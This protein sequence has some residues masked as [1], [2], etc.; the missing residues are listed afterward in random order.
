MEAPASRI[1]VYWWTNMS[2]L[3]LLTALLALSVRLI[4]PLPWYGWVPVL[5]VAVVISH[6]LVERL[7]SRYTNRG[8][9][10]ILCRRDAARIVERSSVALAPFAD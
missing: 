4:V 10:G 7:L 2:V 3:A 9:G 6:L 5:L 8:L 1:N